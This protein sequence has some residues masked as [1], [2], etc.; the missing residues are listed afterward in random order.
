[1]YRSLSAIVANVQSSN[2]R[3][4]GQT[5]PTDYNLLAG[6]M[7]GITITVAAIL[8]VVFVKTLNSDDKKE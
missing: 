3:P 8:L 6:I 5:P 1:M 2:T 4:G 7:I